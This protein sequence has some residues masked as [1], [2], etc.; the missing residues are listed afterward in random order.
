MLTDPGHAGRIQRDTERSRLRLDPA[1]APGIY[2]NGVRQVAVDGKRDGFEVTGGGKFDDESGR[3]PFSLT[4]VPGK[5]GGVRYVDETENM[6]NLSRIAAAIGDLN[7]RDL[8]ENDQLKDAKGAA[9]LKKNMEAARNKSLANSA[10]AAKKKEI[11]KTGNPIPQNARR[12]RI[13][14]WTAS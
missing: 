10:L 5:G 9:D 8:R 4:R 3:A 6:A 11:L 7:L 1:Q 12:G 13:A 14:G 2:S